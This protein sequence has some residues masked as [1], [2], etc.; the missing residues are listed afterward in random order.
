MPA[1]VLGI[2]YRSI[3]GRDKH[4]RSFYAS[5]EAI[6]LKEIARAKSLLA[7]SALRRWRKSG[8]FLIA[9][10]GSVQPGIGK[11]AGEAA[12]HAEDIES[13]GDAEM[14]VIFVED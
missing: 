14:A 8:E 3:E 1:F 9:S 12:K 11:A 10:D 5:F 7:R 4:V 2:K 13:S 6:G